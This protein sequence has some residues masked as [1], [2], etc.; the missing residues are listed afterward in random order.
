MLESIAAGML[1]F[2]VVAFAFV[3]G[4]IAVIGSVAATLLPF[5][6]FIWVSV[7]VCKSIARALD[8]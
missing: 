1:V 7:W 8:S 6:L 5:L 3:A 4:A 2:F